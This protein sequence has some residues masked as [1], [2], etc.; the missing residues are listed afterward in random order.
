MIKAKS[1]PVVGQILVVS[2]E[3]AAFSKGLKHRGFVFVGPTTIYAHM[4]GVGIVYDIPT[5]CF[6]YQEVKLL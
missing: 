6:R 5:P 4:Q 2:P 1:C 3:A